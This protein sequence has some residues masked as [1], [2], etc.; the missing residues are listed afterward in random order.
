VA[1]ARGGGNGTEPPRLRKYPR[2]PHLQGSRVQPGDEDLDCLPFSDLTGRHV[3]VEEKVDGANAAISFDRRGRPRLQSRGHFLS[4]GPRERQFT[5]FKAW[6]AGMAWA[7]WSVLGSRYVLYGEWLFA[8]HTVFYDALPH[9]FLEFDV[10]DTSTGVMLDTP[11][12]RRLL[13][14][15][16]V[17][18]VPVLWS[19]RLEDPTA[20]PGLVGP[21]R[22][23]TPGWRA[24]LAETA[25]RRGLDAEMV[26]AQT[27]R[28]DDM[29]GLYIKVEE[30]GE[31]V[32]RYKWI[33]PTFFT[34]VLDSGGHWLDRPILPNQLLSGGSSAASGGHEGAR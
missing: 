14:G 19:G 13:A 4:G 28:S 17:H 22:Y 2:T 21:S 8:K 29:E 3:V 27:D 31:V 9:H 10:L 34:S 18:A 15:I 7:L 24:A 16:P 5:A 33:R 11:S 32:A 25:R 6:A 1:A 30:R 20:L 12:R 26:A 23:K